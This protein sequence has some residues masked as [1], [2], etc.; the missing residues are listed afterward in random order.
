LRGIRVKK[1]E[2]FDSVET[3]AGAP[4]AYLCIVHQAFFE[5][6]LFFRDKYLSERK[7][8]RNFARQKNGK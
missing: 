7:K 4:T 8:Y 5:N 3:G 1:L 2:I 6:S